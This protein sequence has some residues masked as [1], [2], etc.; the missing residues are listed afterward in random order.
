MR[1]RPSWRRMALTILFKR[2][3]AGLAASAILGS[4]GVAT[5]DSLITGAKIKNGSVTVPTSR[6]AL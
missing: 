2:F 6:S 3:I 4:A 5:A 1:T